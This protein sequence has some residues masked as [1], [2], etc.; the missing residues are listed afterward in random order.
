[1]PPAAPIQAKIADM[2]RRPPPWAASWI[3]RWRDMRPEPMTETSGR[4][5]VGKAPGVF[6]IGH[7]NVSLDAILGLLEAQSIDVVA[8]VRSSPFSRYVPHFDAQPLREALIS[9]AMKYVPLGDELGGRP[10]EVDFYD[11]RG[12]VLYDRMARSERF[13]AGIDRVLRGATTYRLALLC[14]EE[15]PSA[16]HRHLLI[17]RV[18]RERGT[19]VMHIRGDGRI[20]ADS[21]VASR[22]TPTPLQTTLF[23]GVPEERPWTSTRSVLRR[24]APSSSSER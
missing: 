6:S 14:S 10:P 3:S 18:L 4:A 20:E 21:E 2:D 17:G 19:D 15:D 13:Q 22:D 24:R 12:H 7:S 23:G 5:Q 9:R 1:M 11:E 16:C 8:D